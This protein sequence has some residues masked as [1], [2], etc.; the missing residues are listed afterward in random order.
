MATMSGELL[1]GFEQVRKV[2]NRS[3]RGGTREVVVG[4][5]H[6]TR[7]GE[8]SLCGRPIKSLTQSW[9][10]KPMTRNRCLLCIEEG[11]PSGGEMAGH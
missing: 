8:M 2:P 4:D 11:A 5:F 7:D 10:Q 3:T 6:A 9:S 1:G